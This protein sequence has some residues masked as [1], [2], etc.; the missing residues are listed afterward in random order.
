MN[1]M[2]PKGLSYLGLFQI[3][4]LR[5]KEQQKKNVHFSPN[6]TCVEHRDG[7]HTD[8]NMAKRKRRHAA[9]RLLGLGISARSRASPR[10][11]F[12]RCGMRSASR[13]ERKWRIYSRTPA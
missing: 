6:G 12:M 8:K 11:R 5:E 3:K 7:K 4:R 10:M 9:S 13:S 1:Q 2:K